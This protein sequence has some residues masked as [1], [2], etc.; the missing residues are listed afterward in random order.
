VAWK[1]WRESWNISNYLYIA[2]RFQTAE[3]KL[4]DLVL[5]KLRGGRLMG[6]GIGES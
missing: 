2:V 1:N 6:R 3:G 5:I 4:R